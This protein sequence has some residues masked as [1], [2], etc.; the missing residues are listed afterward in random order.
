MKKIGT[1]TLESDRLVLR[2]F[3]IDDA[4]DIFTNYGSDD[5][6]TKYL[7]WPTYKNVE[8]VR[9]YLESVVSGYDDLNNYNWAIELNSNGEVIGNISIVDMQANRNQVEIGYVLS[10]K[11]WGNGIVVEALKRVINFLIEEVKV[12]KIIVETDSRN[13]QSIR[14]AEK[15]G[16]SYVQTIV[17]GGKNNQGIC[18][19]VQYCYHKPTDI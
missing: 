13:T 14:V 3:R 2:K 19:N 15:A 16:M 12:N 10:R 5:E 9:S 11:Y 4:D 6:V 8:S 1:K 18:D 7:R 17:Q